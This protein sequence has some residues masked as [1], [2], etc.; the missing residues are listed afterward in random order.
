MQQF[1]LSLDRDPSY[2]N[3]FGIVKADIN[4]Q[5]A[6]NELQEFSKNNTFLWKHPIAAQKKFE[7]DTIEDLKK[8]KGTNPLKFIDEVTNVRQNIRRIESNIRMKKFKN[9]NE[10]KSWEENLLRGKIR[11]E[12]LSDLIK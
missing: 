8:L 2:K 6:E 11:L 1:D 4:H 7:R 10:L 12:I 9:E 3:C 5:L